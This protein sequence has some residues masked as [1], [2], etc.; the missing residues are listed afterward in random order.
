MRLLIF[1]IAAVFSANQ[2]IATVCFET[3]NPCAD[4]TSCEGFSDFVFDA[5]FYAK[6]QMYVDVGD[7]MKTPK[8]AEHKVATFQVKDWIKGKPLHDPTFIDGYVMN[9]W[10]CTG[11]KPIGILEQGKKYRVYGYYHGSKNDAQI[12]GDDYGLG[13]RMEDRYYLKFEPIAEK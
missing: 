2:A 7:G 8:I 11:V 9:D 5:E 13:P 10:F 1:L 6:D 3:P 4:S 12:M